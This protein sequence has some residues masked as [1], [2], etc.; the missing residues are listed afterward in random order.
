MSKKI[1][2]D[3]W[4]IVSSLKVSLL[5]TV[6]VRKQYFRGSQWYIIQDAFNNK[7]FRIKPEAYQFLMRLNTDAT[8]EDIWEDYL[9]KNPETAPTQEEL[10]TLLTQLHNNNLLYFKNRPKSDDIFERYIEQK[11]KLLRSKAISF[12]YMKI[13]IFDPEKFLQKINPLSK[14]IFTIQGFFIWIVVVGYGVKVVI[15]NSNLAFAQGQGMLSPHNLIFL[16]IALFLLKIMHDAGHAMMCK[17]FGGPV[18]TIGL[19]FLIFTPL[20]YMDASSSSGFKNRWHRALVGSAG[21]LIELFFA[22]IAAVVWSNTGDGFLHSMSFNVM[23]VGSISS[24]VFNANPLMKFDAYY[25]LSD[26]L[27]IPNLFQRSKEQVYYYV[28]KYIFA[29]DNIDPPSSSSTEA[30]WLFA[31]SVSSTFYRFLVSITI[32]LF[33]TDQLFILGLF[34]F[35]ISFFAWV[36]K[37]IYSFLSYLFSSPKLN[38]NRYRAITISAVL[39]SLLSIF[40]VTVPISHSIYAPGVLYPNDF[41]SLYAPDDAY[42][43]EV[44]VKDGIYVNKGDLIA[45]MR[46]QELEIKINI[47][48]AKLA[49]TLAL[50]LNA[51]KNIADLQPL[52][53][54]VKILQ[55]KLK[56]YRQREKKLR[57]Y[58]PISGIWVSKDLQSHKK[59]L[60]KKRELLGNIIPNH[61]FEFRAVV[62]QEKAFDLFVESKLKGNIK[63]NGIASQTIL[64]NNIYVIPYENHKLPSAALGWLGGGDIKVSQDDQSGTKSTEAFFEIRAKVVKSTE[65]PLLLYDRTGILRIVLP[66]QPLGE[67]FIKSLKQMMQKRYQL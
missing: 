59:S 51:Q 49:E 62:S 29:I 52:D 40:I 37:P 60:V 22:A 25:I 14:A 58:A 34:I 23:V 41:T 57:I 26:I 3:S 2:S 21:M 46:S 31:Y 8:V 1:F 9:I 7:F 45:S 42:L 4:H 18:H 17:K 12:L 55:R 54:R 44:K 5:H 16:Y 30:K 20:P 10:V 19:M 32:A 24:L 61:G 28:E 13:P 43:E 35:I 36:L 63:L 15:D 66:D 67:Q 50:K 64:A 47:T 53:S 39:F 65:N 56:W 6:T 38:K 33:V 11:N 48:K 27:E